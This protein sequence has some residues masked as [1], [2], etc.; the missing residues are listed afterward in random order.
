MPPSTAARQQ[1]S[2]KRDQKPPIPTDFL[3]IL[4]IATKNDKK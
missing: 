3:R 4:Q 1:F 2:A